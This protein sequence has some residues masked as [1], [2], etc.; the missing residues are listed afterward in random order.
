MS[1]ADAIEKSVRGPVTRSWLLHDLQALGVKHGMLLMAHCSLSQLGW[2][3]GGAVTVLSALRDAVGEAGTLVLPTFTTA[4]TDP[5]RWQ[6][7]P[8]PEEW[9]NLVREESPP[10]DPATWLSR[11]MGAASD[12]F[13]RLPGVVR[14]GHPSVSWAAQGPLAE[15]VVGEHL[16]GQALGER[17]P[18]GACYALGAY[19]LSLGTVKTTVLHLAEWRAAYPGKHYYAQG[20]AVLLD[21]RRQWVAYQALQGTNSDFEQLRGDFMRDPSNSTCWSAG[22]VGYGAARLFEVRALV[23]YAVEWMP[24]HRSSPCPDS[25]PEQ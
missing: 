17:S 4:N 1:E 25:A 22:T 9:K 24:R 19:V 15:K 2:V 6:H 18:L 14:S 3:I 10:Y 5:A 16:W 13:L 8:V 12:L 11:E 23:D 21:G 7:P 20:A